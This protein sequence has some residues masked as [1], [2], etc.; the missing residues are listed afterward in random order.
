MYPATVDH[1]S[2]VV[3][4]DGKAAL[5]F[6]LLLQINLLYIWYIFRLNLVYSL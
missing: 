5:N 6:K 4:K 2:E 1:L 3:K